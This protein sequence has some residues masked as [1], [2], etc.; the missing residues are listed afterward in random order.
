MPLAKIQTLFVA[1]HDGNEETVF[2]EE[3]ID[4]ILILQFRS[5]WQ[6]KRGS[7]HSAPVMH[8]IRLSHEGR[9]CLMIKS[10]ELL[11]SKTIAQQFPSGVS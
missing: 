1:E 4:G 10:G 8:D 2:D 9:Q 6:R 11:N 7:R 5:D 3:H